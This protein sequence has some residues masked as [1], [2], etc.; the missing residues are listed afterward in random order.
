MDFLSC[1][2]VVPHQRAPSAN[3]KS[4]DLIEEDKEFKA[5][6]IRQRGLIHQM[7]LVKKNSTITKNQV[8]MKIV[9][10]IL[11]SLYSIRNNNYFIFYFGNNQV[12]FYEIVSSI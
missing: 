12:Q 5:F 11:E 10:E 3:R 8:T 1:E 4:P 6:L 2:L 7:R 9:K